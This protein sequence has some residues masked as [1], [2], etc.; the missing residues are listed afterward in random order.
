MGGH[1]SGKVS[2]KVA[3]RSS[4]AD[5]TPIGHQEAIDW[6]MKLIESQEKW[7]DRM[8]KRD[9]RFSDERNRLIA[10]GVILALMLLIAAPSAYAQDNSGFSIS[11]DGQVTQ[12]GPDGGSTYGPDGTGGWDNSGGYAVT[13][14]GGYSTW[15]G[16]TALPS[17]EPVSPDPEWGG[18]S[19]DP[20]LPP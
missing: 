15:Q 10:K 5:E 9:F 1:G 18:P 11:P 2:D 17:E 14:D 13:P 3:R 8:G 6:R 20:L 4:I 16:Q 12:W 7:E 19:D